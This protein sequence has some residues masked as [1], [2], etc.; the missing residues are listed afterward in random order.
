MKFLDKDD[1][2][3]RLRVIGME[4]GD[5]NEIVDVNRHPDQKDYFINYR[6][7]RDA[8]SLY[9]FSQHVAGWLPDGDWKLFQIDNSTLLAPDEEFFFACLL[10]SLNSSF[11]P[12]KNRTLLFEFGNG[13]VSDVSADL[14]ISNLIY[15]FLLFECHGYVVSSSSIGGEILGVQDGFIYF[16]SRNIHVSGARELIIEF[17]KN[18]MS[19]PKWLPLKNTGS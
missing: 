11:D 12:S 15:A 8:A 16:L 7:P 6:A 14:R 3:L 1:A 9:C 10:C 5:W 4:V 17:E 18:P 13:K 2:N 19:S